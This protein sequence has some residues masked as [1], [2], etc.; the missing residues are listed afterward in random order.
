[1]EAGTGPLTVRRWPIARANALMARF[2]R[3]LR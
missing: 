2:G 3:Q 1:V